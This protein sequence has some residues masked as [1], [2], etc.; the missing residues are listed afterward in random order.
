M[1]NL[2]EDIAPD[3]HIVATA[4]V[5]HHDAARCYV[6]DIV[7]DRTGRIGGWPI[8][9]RVR[10]AN[11]TKLRIERGNALALPCNAAA[12]EGIADRG[13]VEPGSAPEVCIVRVVAHLC[14]S[15]IMCS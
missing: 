8:Q 4:V 14:R 3:R 6:V 15:S 13:G 1:R 5:E 10:S 7:T 2:R 9:Q 11:K 12:I